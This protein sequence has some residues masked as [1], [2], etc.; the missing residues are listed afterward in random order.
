MGAWA[1]VAVNTSEWLQWAR[2]A[3]FECSAA[4]WV[5]SLFAAHQLAHRE[6]HSRPAPVEHRGVGAYRAAI[7]AGSGSI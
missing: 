3:S 1:A 5:R 2:E 6:H 7:S 4:I